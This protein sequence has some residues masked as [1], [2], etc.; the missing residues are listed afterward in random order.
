MLSAE[1]RVGA[2]LAAPRRV[3]SD[4][5][6]MRI[7]DLSMPVWEASTMTAQRANPRLVT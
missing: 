7:H 1:C 4:E 6:G 2:L 5:V 3:P